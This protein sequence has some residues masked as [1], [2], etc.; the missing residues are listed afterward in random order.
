MGTFIKFGV[1]AAIAFGVPIGLVVWA[2]YG[3][4]QFALYAGLGGG[5]AFGVIMVVVMAAVSARTA[6]NRPALDDGEV[7]IKEDAANHFVGMVAV[8]GWLF[9]TNRRLH[10]KSHAANTRNHETSYP[11][12]EITG[13][14]ATRTMGLVPNSFVATM[15]SGADEK[16]VVRGRAKWV[17][18]VENARSAAAG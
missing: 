17:A 14:A 4:G 18:A 6:K 7:L 13:L 12:A 5:I 9:L 1:F 2:I 3:D 16:F 10:F 15:A 11:L 8:G